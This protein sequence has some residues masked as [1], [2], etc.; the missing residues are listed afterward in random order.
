MKALTSLAAALVLGLTVLV[1]AASAETKLVMVE[2]QG[3]VW[4]ER[5]LAEIGPI[6]PKTAEGKVAPLQMVDLADPLPK[7]ITFTRSLRFTPTFV[8]VIDGQEVNRIEGY[9]GEDFFWG[10][11]GMMLKSANVQVDVAG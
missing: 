4:C 11:L 10:L 3:C 9:P 1:G 8:L 2:E 6:Y 7:D 5:W